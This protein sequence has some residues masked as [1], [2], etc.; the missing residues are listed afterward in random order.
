MCIVESETAYFGHLAAYV[1][2][3]S[4]SSY[5]TNVNVILQ[6]THNN[7]LSN[8]WPLNMLAVGVK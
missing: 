5:M 6:P 1:D 2:S 7:P 4:L 3:A 8:Q